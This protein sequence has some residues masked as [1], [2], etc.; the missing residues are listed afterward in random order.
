MGYG[1]RI[2]F[3]FWKRD[4]IFF[5]FGYDLREKMILL[6]YVRFNILF[7]RNSKGFLVGFIC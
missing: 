3:K 7:F 6:I 4:L 5:F 2:D 1:F